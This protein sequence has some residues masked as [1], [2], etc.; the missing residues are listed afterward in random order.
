VLKVFPGLFLVL[1]NNHQKQIVALIILLE[2]IV[3]WHDNI[4]LHVDL[5]SHAI[6]EEEE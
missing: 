2:L 3:S 5:N 1:Q 6:Y 4:Y